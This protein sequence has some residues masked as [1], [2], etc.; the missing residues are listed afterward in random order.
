MDLRWQV[1][2]YLLASILLR[3]VIARLAASRTGNARWTSRLMAGWPVSLLRFAYY[4]GLPYV[5]LVLGVL[6]SRYLGLV[7][8]D[9]LPAVGDTLPAANI[10]APVRAAVSLL[11]LSWLPD[12]GRL[13]GLTALMSLL[14]V[15]TWLAY[16]HVQRS[17][18]S[19]HE[20]GVVPHHGKALPASFSRSAYAAVHWSFYRACA[21]LLAGDLYLGVVGGVI[22]VCGEW[23]ICNR[24]GR[25]GANSTPVELRL[26][27]A[28][29]LVAT[30]AIFYFA[31]NLWLL[32][33][34]HWLLARL[35]WRIVA[36]DRRA[37]FHTHRRVP[38]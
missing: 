4:V 15:A 28:S 23:L 19:A 35:C 30:S 24:W 7:G 21:W 20:A 33:P 8:L 27:D 22:L 5:T 18:V 14:L 12:L 17:P 36:G 16:R 11:L 37:V 31:P 32:M 25:S 26:V 38:G 9:R 1:V 3:L 13:A 10:L 29:V 6:P 34:V 2:A